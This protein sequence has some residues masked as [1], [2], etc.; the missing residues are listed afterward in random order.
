MAVLGA[1][2]LVGQV[3]VKL[4][5]GHPW[6]RLVALMASERSA[7]KPYREAVR[8][9]QDEPLEQDVGEMVVGPCESGEDLPLVFS[10]LGAEAAL[11]VEPAFAEAGSL[12]VSNA[13]AHRMHPDVP[14]VIPEVNPDHLDLVSRQSF[15]KGA[16]LANPNCS[17]TGLVLPLKPLHDAFGV[18]TVQVVTLQSLSGGGL[19]GLDLEEAQDN[20]IP[21]IEGEEEKMEREPGKILGSLGDT[22][23][24]PAPLAVSAQCN[25]VPVREG[26]S[27]SVSVGLKQKVTTEEL[28][29]AFEGFAAD[30]EVEGLPSS[31]EKVLRL[32]GDEDGPQPRV[33]KDLDGGMACS[34]GRI[35]ACPVLDHRFVTLSHNLFRGAAGGTLLLAE[36]A[37]S[38]GLV[39]GDWIKE[40]RGENCQ[41]GSR[42]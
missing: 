2:G 42:G 5:M 25:R 16:I 4:L 30:P 8:W 29:G 28:A 35:R 10:A 15:G 11:T 20:V 38:R 7:G 22:G 12:V 36:L 33:H 21:L 41:T 32:I 24:N 27:L 31:P 6:F 3:L 13:A 14:L 19:A 23:V 34:I 9:V 39:E 26:H 18:E 17:T 37:V 40:G 1:T